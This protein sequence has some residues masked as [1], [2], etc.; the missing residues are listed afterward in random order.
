MNYNTLQR[1]LG[2]F[3]A[4]GMACNASSSFATPP[5]ESV[6]ARQ[7]RLLAKDPHPKA[8]YRDVFRDGW[9]LIDG[10]ILVPNDFF[11]QRD[12]YVTNLWA[13]GVVPY[14][15]DANLSIAQRTL[16]IEAMAE[17]E[18]VAN[19]DFRPKD[20][21]DLNW[22]HIRDSSGDLVPGNISFGIG[23]NPV[24]GQDVYIASW[25]RS[26]TKWIIVHELGHVLGFWH[27][28]QRTDRDQYVDIISENALDIQEF[29]NFSIVPGTNHYGPYDY[30]SLMHYGQCAFSC[31]DE[32]GAIFPCCPG[33]MSCINNLP[34]CR[35]ILILDPADRAQ[36][37]NAL[38]QRDH[39]SDWDARVMQW[40]YPPSGA[41]WEFVDR[42]H[43]GDEQGTFVL[44]WDSIQEGV[45]G[46]P[47]GGVLWVLEPGNYFA[48]G[49]ISK[50]LEMRAPMGGVV[51]VGP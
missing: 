18:V 45:N 16:I 14:E 1:L 47:A 33:C 3:V 23:M 6:R 40:M 38:G 11:E 49:V 30:D 2:A 39:L 17:W 51:L 13:N 29:F 44:P 20:L 10:D 34:Q 4:A 28:Q 9:M 31:C 35:T 32:V 42:T 48:A 46:V 5:D 25:G 50:R 12:N 22:M 15:F 27:E 24:G 43:T 21:F 36:W 26:D 19:V 37:Q 41:G 7:A 8:P